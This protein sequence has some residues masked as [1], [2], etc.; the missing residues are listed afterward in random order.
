VWEVEYT[1]D[2][3]AWWDSLDEGEQDE[4]AKVVTLLQK[5]GPQLPFPFS[6][7]IGGSKHGHMR[8][9]RVQYKGNPYRALYAF[10]PR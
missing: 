7:A 8:E 1:D 5:Y 9:L 10:D 4:V 2:F 6:S 3:E